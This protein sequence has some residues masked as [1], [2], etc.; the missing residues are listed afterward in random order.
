MLQY[1]LLSCTISMLLR[2]IGRCEIVEGGVRVGGLHAY[3]EVIRF[4]R[5]I[6][7]HP[8]VMWPQLQQL[9]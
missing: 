5:D 1:V 9:G 3:S 6:Y 8:S 2:I 4:L 7:A